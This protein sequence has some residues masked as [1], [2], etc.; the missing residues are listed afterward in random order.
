[1]QSCECPRGLRETKSMPT[2]TGMAKFLKIV[3]ETILEFESNCFC[4]WL[5]KS[6]TFEL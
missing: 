6:V 2:L 4:C 5:T 3:F 1:M